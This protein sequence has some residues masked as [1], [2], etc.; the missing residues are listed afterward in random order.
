MDPCENVLFTIKTA[1]ED[2]LCPPSVSMMSRWVRMV[3]VVSAV[4]DSIIENYCQNTAVD[5]SFKWHEVMSA[6]NHW[7]M[8]FYI[9]I[10]TSQL[11]TD[12]LSYALYVL[13]R[14][15][16]YYFALTKRSLM[17]KIPFGIGISCA[18]AHVLHS[19]MLNVYI[20]L[21][22]AQDTFSDSWWI[23]F[24]SGKVLCLCVTL[25]STFSC[26]H[27]FTVW[28]WNINGLHRYSP[29]PICLTTKSAVQHKLACTHLDSGD[30]EGWHWKLSDTHPQL[31][32]HHTLTCR[33]RLI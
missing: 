25:Y 20:S 16:R 4:I 7:R 26:S 3:V 33:L 30:S 21:V 29:F 27:L 23:L 12:I 2:I 19:L 24:S 10:F 9:L 15:V 28:L 17:H 31:G 8:N 13:S 11:I 6:I 22:K 14:H 5:L 1:L 32:V 18:K